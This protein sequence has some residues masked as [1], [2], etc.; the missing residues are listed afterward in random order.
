MK[1]ILKVL[2]SLA[3]LITTPCTIFADSVVM[4]ELDKDATSGSIDLVAEHAS[5]YYIKLPKELNISE[6]STTFNI[7]AKGD[8]DGSKMIV[9]E[10][11]KINGEDNYLSDDAG[12][13]TAKK[14][15]VTAGNGIKAA[16]LKVAE[17]DETKGTTMTIVHDALEAGTWSGV[18]PIT[19]RLADITQ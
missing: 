17:Y 13:K 15:T 5:E 7:Y 1:K 14:L 19:I 12:L 10:E 4:E 18:L 9:F 11:N 3:V 16:D 6:A 2:L 8:V